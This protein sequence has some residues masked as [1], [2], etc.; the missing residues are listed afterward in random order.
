MDPDLFHRADLTTRR[1][2]AVRGGSAVVTSANAPGGIFNFIS[3]TGSEQFGGEMLVTGGLQGESNPL[4]R[5]D[6]NLG[7]LL[8]N[9]GL[10]YN[11]GGFYRYDQGARN[12][13]INWE[14]G[15]QLKANIS[16]KT[17]NG[18]VKVY[19][20]YLNDKVNRYQGSSSN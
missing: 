20:K 8:G 4:F 3:K 17:K 14:N 9:N 2:E 7:G 13:D 11:I 19:G 18:F 12:T 16:K 15:G 10:T 5:Y 1:L 6:L